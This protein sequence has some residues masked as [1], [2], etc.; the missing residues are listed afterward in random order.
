LQK[1]TVS[2]DDKV[3]SLL[4]HIGGVKVKLNAFLTSALDESKWS[5]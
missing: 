5:D 3:T 2:K 1:R 4:G